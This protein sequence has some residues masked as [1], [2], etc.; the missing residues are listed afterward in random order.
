MNVGVMNVGQSIY[1]R[2]G[3]KQQSSGGVEP[4]HLRKLPRLKSDSCRENPDLTNR[5]QIVKDG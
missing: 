5:G 2:A 1:A 4:L 3:L